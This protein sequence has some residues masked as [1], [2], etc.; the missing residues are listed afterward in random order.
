MLKELI[1]LANHLD[2]RGFRKEADYLDAIINKEAIGPLA[3]PAA[4]TIG[5]EHVFLAAGT[6][7]MA[8]LAAL[9]IRKRASKISKMNLKKR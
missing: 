7:A 1:H 3:I 4:I 9:G 5:T 2:K 6:L 8:S